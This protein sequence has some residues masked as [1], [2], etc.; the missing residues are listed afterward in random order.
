MNCTAY[1]QGTRMKGSSS[2]DRYKK[3]KTDAQIVDIEKAKG[4]R[5]GWW[6][7][8]EGYNF[9]KRLTRS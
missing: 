9:V 5:Q 3:Y 4:T 2:W 1:V 8:E 6:I 7:C